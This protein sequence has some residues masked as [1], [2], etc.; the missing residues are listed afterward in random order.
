[1][2]AKRPWPSGAL[3]QRRPELGLAGGLRPPQ[4]APAPVEETAEAQSLQRKCRVC[5][6][7]NGGSAGRQPIAPRSTDP[8]RLLDS[9][10][11]AAV[12]AG[13]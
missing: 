9:K 6:K 5:R 2:V 10:K 3:A 7:P 13:P 8:L 12:R 11:H 4:R 1:M